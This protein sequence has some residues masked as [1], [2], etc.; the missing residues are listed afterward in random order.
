MTA[1]EVAI[2]T[3]DDATAAAVH[4]AKFFCLDEPMLKVLNIGADPGFL[5][6]CTGMIDQG[7]SLKAVNEQ[8]DIVGVFLSEIKQKTV[9]V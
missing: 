4:L 1:I 2:L 7:V 9:G 6:M 3:K 5:A 8:G